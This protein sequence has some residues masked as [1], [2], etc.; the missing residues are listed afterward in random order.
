MDNQNNHPVSAAISSTI[1]LSTALFAVITVQQVQA[2]LTMTASAIAIL[3]GAFAIRYY[4]F[5]TKKITKQ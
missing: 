1:S 3:S 2:Y 4:Y 5:A